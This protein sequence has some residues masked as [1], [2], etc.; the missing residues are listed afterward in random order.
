MDWSQAPL[1]YAFT[2]G[3][4]EDIRKIIVQS[5]LKLIVLKTLSQKYPTQKRAGRVTQVVEHLPTS[6]CEALSSNSSPTTTKQKQAN[7]QNPKKKPE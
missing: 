3:Y 7:K 6:G 4:S 5:Q 2:P 1:A